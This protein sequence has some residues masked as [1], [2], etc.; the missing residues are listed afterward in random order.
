MPARS[1][2][3]I[4]NFNLSKARKTAPLV[5]LI[6]NIASQKPLTCHTNHLG[7]TVSTRIAQVQHLMVT[8]YSHDSGSPD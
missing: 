4:R 2:L 3:N 1:A 5:K 8:G 7:Y 6:S